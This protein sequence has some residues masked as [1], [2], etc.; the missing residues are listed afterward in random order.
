MY[1]ILVFSYSLG[2][3]LGGQDL[4]LYQQLLGR[5]PQGTLHEGYSCYMT[6]LL[7]GNYQK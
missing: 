6:Y 4:E 3:V 2:A 7:A 1:E 5:E